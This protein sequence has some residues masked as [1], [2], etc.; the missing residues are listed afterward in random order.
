[1]WNN[2]KSP[3]SILS[4]FHDRIVTY[5]DACCLGMFYLAVWGVSVAFVIRGYRGYRMRSGL[6]EDSRDGKS[7]DLL[8]EVDNFCSMATPITCDIN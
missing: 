7:A 1:M 8:Y 5:H 3:V 2:H 6:T 4:I